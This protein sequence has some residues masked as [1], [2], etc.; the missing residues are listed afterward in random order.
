M[1][2]DAVVW[3]PAQSEPPGPGGRFWGWQAGIGAAPF[4]HHGYVSTQLLADVSFG[5]LYGKGLKLDT[6]QQSRRPFGTFALRLANSIHLI[7]PLDLV[8]KVGLAIPWLRPNFVYTDE[9]DSAV[10][11]HRPEFLIGEAGLGLSMDLGARREKRL[12]A[13]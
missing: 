12:G 5:F 13:P 2:G 11:V 1:R 7:G 8:A 6:A 10:R 9:T 4:T 3:L